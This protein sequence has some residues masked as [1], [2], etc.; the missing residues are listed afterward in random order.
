MSRMPG[1]ASSLFHHA[2]ALL[3]A[4]V[5]ITAA[6]C[7]PRVTGHINLHIDDDVATQIKKNETIYGKELAPDWVV[8]G[9]DPDKTDFTATVKIEIVQGTRTIRGEI[10]SPTTLWS[11]VPGHVGV[12]LYL[13][14]PLSATADKL[15]NSSVEYHGTGYPPITV[16]QLYKVTGVLQPQWQDW[17]YVYVPT[18]A[19]FIEAAK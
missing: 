14:Q 19:D 1:R 4:A 6:G 7:K 11:Q 3:L 12:I 8:K 10:T 13:C 2:L 9:T 16:G 17:P 5:T 15:S 18:A